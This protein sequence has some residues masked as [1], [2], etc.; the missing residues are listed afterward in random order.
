MSYVHRGR[1]RTIS[2]RTAPRRLE[3][4]GAVGRRL[5]PLANLGDCSRCHPDMLEETHLKMIAHVAAFG[6]YTLCSVQSQAN[7]KVSRV[8]LLEMFTIARL[9]A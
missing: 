8:Q 5:C 2:F 3:I 1:T 9:H 7:A 6:F 4:Q